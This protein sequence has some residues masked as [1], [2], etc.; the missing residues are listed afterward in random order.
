MRVRYCMTL[1]ARSSP[2]IIP[3]GTG[4]AVLV[5]AVSCL[6]FGSACSSA[7][8]GAT[9][10]RPASATEPR[11]VRLVPVSLQSIART[12]V[13]QG[14]L[15]ADEQTTLA[16]KVS[17]R[18]ASI[19]VDLG[20]RVRK[21]D[22]VA[23]L[24][25]TDFESRVRQSE[26]A[27]QQARARLGLD[28]AATVDTVTLE[29]TSP[30]RQAKAVLDEASANVARARKL[31][32]SGVMSRAELDS[33]EATYSVA[34]ARYQESLEE[35]RN[36]QSVLAQRKSE[37]DLARQQRSDAVLRAPF[38]GAIAAKRVGTGEVVAIGAPV[39]DLV[40][41]NP[42]RMR[43]EIPERETQGV[44]LGKPVSVRVEGEAADHHGR[45]ARISPVVNE[46]NRVLVVEIEVQNSDGA[47]RPGSF[48][49]ASITTAIEGSA[50]TVPTTAIVTFAGIEKVFIVKDGKAAEKIVTTGRRDASGIEITSGLEAGEQIVEDPGNL[51]VGQE[52]KTGQVTDD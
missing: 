51:V 18:V 49:T 42:L 22:V 37:L 52:L 34:E 1:I 5:A 17:G 6:V 27:L 40:R 30:V 46:K 45:V 2:R 36:R 41:V 11:A 47:L 33:V 24:D 23:H 50:L 35:A 10:P 12:V 43:A 14:T 28:P 25:E 29:Q 31:N 3:S 16:F 44:A 32:S 48:A 15:T 19:T 7:P 9:G 38:D 8:A 4:T 26:A 39:L 21:G 13:G 20:S